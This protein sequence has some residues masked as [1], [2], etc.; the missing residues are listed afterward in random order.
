[1]KK[2]HIKVKRKDNPSS[3]SYWHEFEV[4]YKDGMTVVDAL[5][6]IRKNPVTM[7]GKKVLPVVWES[8]CHGEKCGACAMVVNGKVRLAC[9]S[10]VYKLKK[11]IILKPMSKF[12]VIRDLWI[13][14]SGMFDALKKMKNLT[15]I[16]GYHDL[17]KGPLYTEDQLVALYKYSTCISCGAC[18]QAC[19]QYNQQSPYVGAHALGQVLLYNLKPHTKNGTHK[20]LNDIMGIGGVVECGHA[21]N[22]AKVCPKDIPLSD[23][24]SR[25]NWQVNLKALRNFLR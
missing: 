3:Y 14:R 21:E 15:K 6:E 19:P 9:S 17:G 2:A 11:P 4:D 24:I 13:D 22:C 8:V 10:L 1:M 18:L 25:L 12:P 5:V 23:A 20:R 7:D 16:D